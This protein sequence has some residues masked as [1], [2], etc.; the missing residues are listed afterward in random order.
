MFRPFCAAAGLLPALFLPVLLGVVAA[1][2]AL[3]GE[4]LDRIVE[5]KT[6]RFGYRVDAPPFASRVDGRPQGFTVAL[7]GRIAGAILLTSKLPELT[8][9]FT[10]IDTD[11]RFEAVA[12]GKIDVLC[13]ATTATL[14]RR[15]MVSFTI[16]TFS[17]G[18]GAIVSADAP[19]ALAEAVLDAEPSSL[20][21]EDFRAGLAGRRLGARANTT[22]ETFLQEQLIDKGTKIRLETFDDHAAGLDAVANGKIEAYFADQA[23]L[24]AQRGERSD[25][26]KLKVSPATFSHE[27]YALALARDD[28]EL[29]LVMDRALSHLYRTGAIFDVY[30]RFFGRPSAEAV[31]FYRAVSLPE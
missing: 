21:P 24:L 22:A 29:R 9:T 6:I 28:E 7:C 15:E 4:A 23:I 11:E 1:P 26:G 20:A 8:A 13:G 14:A 31:F 12:D 17:T 18:V 16:P 3:A 25:A 27:P 2:P 10:E 5:R 30:S 19:A